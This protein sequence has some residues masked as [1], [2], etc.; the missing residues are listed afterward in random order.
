MKFCV[1]FITASG[2]RQAEKIAAMLISKKLAACVNTIKGVSSVFI[3]QSKKE[4]V[5]EIGMNI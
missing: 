3:W 2:S 1:V 5:S 4:K